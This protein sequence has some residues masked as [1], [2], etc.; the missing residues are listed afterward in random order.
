MGMTPSTPMATCR[1]VALVVMAAAG[2]VGHTLGVD[3]LLHHLSP[4]C[5]AS[6]FNDAICVDARQAPCHG[7]SWPTSSTARGRWPCTRL[8]TAPFWLG[9]W[10]AL[11]VAYLHVHGQPGAACAYQARLYALFTPC[12]DNK[13][14]LDWFNENILA[15]GCARSGT[16]F[17]KAGDQAVDRW[18]LSSMAPGSWWAGL[19]A[20]C[21]RLQTGFLYHYALVDDLWACS[22]CLT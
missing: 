20:V 6:L 4:C 2:L 21:A 12:L 16:G 18:W 14:Y 22:C 13:Y 5:L 11:S 8:S 3:R 9:S 15:R 19:P 7:K 1:R 10:L 17:W